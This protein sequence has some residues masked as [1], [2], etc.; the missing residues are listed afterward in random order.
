MATN[1]EA[2]LRE[3]AENY[4][5]GWLSAEAFADVAARVILSEGFADEF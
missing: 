5:D 2:L 3:L 1:R 4:R